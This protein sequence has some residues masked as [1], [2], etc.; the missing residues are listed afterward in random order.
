MTEVTLDDSKNCF[1]KFRLYFCTLV[2]PLI[3]IA[4]TLFSYFYEQTIFESVCAVLIACISSLAVIFN[5]VT[6]QNTVTKVKVK[7]NEESGHI[8]INKK[9]DFKTDNA[10]VHSLCW[11]VGCQNKYDN[12]EE[13]VKHHIRKY[14]S[15][16]K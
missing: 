6:T 14:N 16:P 3:I 15:V 5:F 12:K 13:Y 1:Q 4:L 2:V 9:R 7:K 8:D 10:I 11:L